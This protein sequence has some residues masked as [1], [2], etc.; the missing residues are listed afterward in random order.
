MD[1]VYYFDDDLNMCPVKKYFEELK[2]DKTITD[3]RKNKY[4]V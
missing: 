1:V 4:F 2:S 3:D